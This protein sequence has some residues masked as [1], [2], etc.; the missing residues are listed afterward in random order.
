MP[1]KKPLQTEI[2]YS[3]KIPVSAIIALEREVTGLTHGIAN[4]TLHIRDGN[5]SRYAISRE[6][7][8]VPQGE[9]TNE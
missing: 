6:R 7:S 9:T 5:L 8:I 4:L 1:N 2:G 3:G